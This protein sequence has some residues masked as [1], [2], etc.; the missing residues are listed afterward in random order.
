MR[1]GRFWIADRDVPFYDG[2][3]VVDKIAV[4]GRDVVF[5][6]CVMENLP[7]GVFNPSRPVESCEMPTSCPLL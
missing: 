2:A 5:V 3:S 4:F 1:A 6:L 7:T